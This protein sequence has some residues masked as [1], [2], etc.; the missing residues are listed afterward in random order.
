M[1][2]TLFTSNQRRHNYLINVLSRICEKLFVIQEDSKTPDEIVPV[3]YTSSKNISN[4]FEKVDFAQK[5]VFYNYDIKNFK[6]K[7]KIFNILSGNLN[8]I[9][10][11]K[12]NDF[13]KSDIYVVFGS[14][15]IKNELVDFLIKKKAINIHMGISP[16]YRGTDCNF[17][18]LFDGNPH[19]V[20]STVHLLSK[21]LD[22]GP[23]LY[24]ALS[25]I[26]TDPFEYTMSSVKSAFH[27]IA[28][29]INDN[30]I[31][32]IQPLVQDNSKE[33]RY[34]QKKDFN[35][36]IVNEFFEKKIDLNSKNFDHSF[37]KDPYFLDS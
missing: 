9:S 18:A 30:S 27:S 21:G 28:K 22:S 10:L 1:K 7:V 14:S 15:Y 20:G 32:K 5:K 3:N 29:R 34:S 19:L 37:L 31:L 35:D 33:I 11:K 8:E 2:I 12:M 4:Y 26:K 17:W 36:K 13:F 23:I 16:F 24:H 6:D 25:N